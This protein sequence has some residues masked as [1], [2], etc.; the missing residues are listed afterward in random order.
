MF[1]PVA[2]AEESNDNFLWTPIPRQVQ[3]KIPRASLRYWRWW[4]R[5]RPQLFL[6]MDGVLADTVQHV[7]NLFGVVSE[8]EWNKL[9]WKQIQKHPNFYGTQPLMKDTIDLWNGSLKFHPNPIVLTG[10]PRSMPQVLQQKRE[11]IDKHFGKHVPMIGC[12]SKD[13]HLFAHKYDILV[14]DRTKFIVEWEISGGIYI[15]HKNAESS[16]SLLHT[17]YSKVMLG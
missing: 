1:E 9:P 11:W 17:A 13:K 7:K 3:T 14:D 6:D 5:D 12:E 4:S 8:L 15:V 16:L 10:I 2:V